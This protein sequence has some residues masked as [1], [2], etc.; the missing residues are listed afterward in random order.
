MAIFEDVD[1]FEFDIYC[2]KCIEKHKKKG[3]LNNSRQIKKN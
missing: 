3:W 2:P 1:E